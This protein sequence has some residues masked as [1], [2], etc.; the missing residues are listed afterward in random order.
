MSNETKERE[1]RGLRVF[2][3]QLPARR[4]YKLLPKLGNILAPAFSKLEGVDLTNLEQDIS[5]MAPAFAELFAKLDEA[6]SDDLMESLLYSTSVVVEG[7]R[8]DL[9]NP[10]EIDVAFSGNL[11]A[12]METLWFA[13]ELNFRDFFSAASEKA[14]S[15]AADAAKAKAE[16]S[17]STSATS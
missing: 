3:T 1:I 17:S 15:V 12:M 13:V 9:C 16:E 6:E 7:K 5:K 14:A 4:A 8:L 11:L 10:H 2:S